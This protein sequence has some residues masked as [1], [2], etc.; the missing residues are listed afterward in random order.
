MEMW[1]KTWRLA[2][3]PQISTPALE[4][5]ATALREDD[6]RLLQGA[7]TSP[8]PL[9]CVQDWPTEAACVIGFCGAVNYGGFKMNPGE[10]EPNKDA[11]PVATVEEFFARVCFEADQILKESAGCRW[12][13]NWADETPR[14]EMRRELL[15]E[16]EL[17]LANRQ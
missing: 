9:A 7:T 6:P 16:V 3:A 15:P 1:R 13:L 4:A 2:I 8:P 11:A 12:F 17:V 14:E 10:T 5:L